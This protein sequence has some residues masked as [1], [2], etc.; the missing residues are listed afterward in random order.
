MHAPLVH[1]L[2]AAIG[3]L[4]PNSIAAVGG[5]SVAKLTSLFSFIARNWG[6]AGMLDTFVTRASS[7]FTLH[8]PSLVVFG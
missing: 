1:S 5:W 6:K 8:S 4:I 7:P 2:K 3:S